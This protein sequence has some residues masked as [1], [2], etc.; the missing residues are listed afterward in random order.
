MVGHAHAAG[1]RDGTR[2]EAGTIARYFLRAAGQARLMPQ[3]SPWLGESC[4]LHAKSLALA[5]NIIDFE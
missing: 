4:S 1:F 2:T 3:Q 5:L